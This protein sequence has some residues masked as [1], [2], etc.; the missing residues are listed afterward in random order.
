M[1]RKCNFTLIELLIVIAIIAILAS[2]LLPALKKARATAKNISCISNLKQIGIGT[3]NYVSDFNGFMP[4]WPGDSYTG[5]NLGVRWEYRGCVLSVSAKPYGL[6]TVFVEP[7]YIPVNT[8]YCP[9]KDKI[10]DDPSK[11]HGDIEGGTIYDTSRY[12]AHEYRNLKSSYHMRPTLKYLNELNSTDPI[13]REYMYRLNNAGKLVIFADFSHRADFDP[14]WQ[15][16]YNNGMNVLYGDI[17]AK[18]F[19][20]IRKK[21]IYELSVGDQIN[22]WERGAMYLKLDRGGDWDN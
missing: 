4:A 21:L 8:F 15:H 2:M 18:T 6:A 20:N 13:D 19:P 1:K 12:L 17:S 9:A 10:V 5:D 3:A 22:T 11:G 16:K 7:E 14:H